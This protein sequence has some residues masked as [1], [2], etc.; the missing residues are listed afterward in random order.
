M[1]GAKAK[2]VEQLLPVTRWTIVDLEPDRCERVAAYLFGLL[3]REPLRSKPGWEAERIV[4]GMLATDLRQ[5]AVDAGEPVGA[6]RDLRDAQ[7]KADELSALRR[8]ELVTRGY[9]D[10]ITEAIEA[11]R[12]ERRTRETTD[13]REP[14]LI[15]A[16]APAPVTPTAE[17]PG[18][19]DIP[20]WA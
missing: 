10:H 20:T 4:L 3:E 2:T 7:T 15:P 18:D 1:T 9:H 13:V 14:A 16:S 12:A 11:D 19:G 8:I 6:H 5:M 17:P